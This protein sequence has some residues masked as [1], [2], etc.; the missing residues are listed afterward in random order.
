MVVYQLYIFS[1]S[2]AVKLP[3][4]FFKYCQ[5]HSTSSI[6]PEELYLQSFVRCCKEIVRTVLLRVKLVL[7]PIIFTFILLFFQYPIDNTLEKWYN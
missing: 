1:N 7:F 5:S 4:N 2:L 3:L 6:G